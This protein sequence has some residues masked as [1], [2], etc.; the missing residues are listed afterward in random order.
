MLGW[1]RNGAIVLLSAF[2]F[3]SGKNVC[4]RREKERKYY[5][6]YHIPNHRRNEYTH[7]TTYP[8]DLEKRVNVQAHKG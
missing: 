7:P 2:N 3:A 1:G 6:I 5:P 4:K 8:T